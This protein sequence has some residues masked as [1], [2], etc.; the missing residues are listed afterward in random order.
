MSISQASLLGQPTRSL[1]W[2]VGPDA[3]LSSTM[4]TTGQL[5]QLGPVASA[6]EDGL[7]LPLTEA[8]TAALAGSA[9]GIANQA[10]LDTHVLLE[11]VGH[12][13]AILNGPLHALTQLGETAGLGH[14][15]EPGHLLTDV[16]AVPGAVADGGGA[17]SAAPAL[18]DLDQAL[19]ATE[20]LVASVVGTATGSDLLSPGG[21]L[22]PVSSL[23]NAAVLDVHATI[24]GLGHDLPILNEALHG[25]TA[26]GEAV[27]LGHLG[28]G[29]N[30]LTDLANVPGD[31]L[32]A[33]GLAALSP[34]LGDLGTVT[35]A[36]TGLLDDVL[37]IPTNLLG[38]TPTGT[39]LDGVLAPATSLLG[40]LTGGSGPTG[41]L[42]GDGGLLQPVGS[43]ANGLI[44]GVHA[45]LEQLGHDIPI[46]NA[47]LHE[48]IELG[49]S[50]GLGALGEGNNLLT[51]AAHLPA[52]VLGGNGPAGVGQ[53]LADAGH[54]VD[55][56]AGVLG[57]VPGVLDGVVPGGAGMGT[58]VDGVLAPVLSTVGSIEG[59][60]DPIT[61]ILGGLAGGM[62]GGGSEGTHPLIDVAVGPVTPTP[63]ANVGVLTPP[64]E[65]SH[66]IEVGAIAVGADQPSLIS[67]GLLSGDGLPSP[68][69]GGGSDGLV[70]H[71]TE[72]APSVG[73]GST[74]ANAAPAASVDLG[75]V[76]IDL[77]GHAEVQHTDP[78]PHTATGGLHLLGL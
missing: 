69:A 20:G 40:G 72:I 46:L 31:L 9:S 32:H 77:G 64:A 1:E 25:L 12:E 71:L 49:T 58:P 21:A 62:T 54:V 30:L 78:T 48:V 11:N 52:D 36:A 14:I 45:G 67:A 2:L 65:P 8:A 61:G 50:I 13:I 35:G 7:Q 19:G 5:G 24:E 37:R 68:W 22:A 6:V 60:T 38:G 10:V 47:P 16:L 59:G 55:A 27:G 76:S 56:A 75:L 43:A 33:D 44:D 74:G 18:T 53:V 26:L 42:L 34:I 41:D 29:G 3:L 70:G 15:G 63:A 4:E 17:A 39:P 57:T 23:A 66:T 51:D 28:T 73:S